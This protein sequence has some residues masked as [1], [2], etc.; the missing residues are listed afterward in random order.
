VWV[1]DSPYPP[2]LV[3]GLL[4]MKMRFNK[5]A[6][7]NQYSISMCRWVTMGWGLTLILAFTLGVSLFGCIW[8]LL[9]VARVVGDAENTLLLLLLKWQL[10]GV[11]MTLVA[12]IVWQ[13]F[14]HTVLS[15][16]YK[17]T[18]PVWQRITQSVSV[19]WRVQ[20]VLRQYIETKNVKLQLYVQ[21]WWYWLIAANIL[22]VATVFLLLRDNSTFHLPNEYVL[23][24]VV[25][26]F[27][28]YC[29]MLV[30]SLRLV[31]TIMHHVHDR[32]IYVSGE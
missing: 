30:L 32:F 25:I 15:G 13:Y 10:L 24:L 19:I 28:V 26:M 5:R 18:L 16:L 20:P 9:N 3:E 21:Y 12:F 8:S 11:Y 31:H 14:G 1:E 17:S 23:W 22:K 27:A 29:V 6:V 2:F 7:I 4:Y